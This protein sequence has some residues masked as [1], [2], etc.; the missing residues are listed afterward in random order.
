MVFTG[1]ALLV[2]GCSRTDFQQGSPESLYTS[3]HSKIYSLPND[4]LVYPAH[5][6]NGHTVST[7][8]EE[9][10]HNPRLNLGVD[11]DGFSAIMNGL[12][13]AYPKKIKESLPA[14]MACG[15]LKSNPLNPEA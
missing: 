8:G 11:M 14:N 15:E 2:R 10:A 9:K 5:D 6:Y 1:N 7:V 12:N 13:L 3:V 4:T